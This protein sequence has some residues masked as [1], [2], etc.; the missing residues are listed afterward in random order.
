MLWLEGHSGAEIADVT[1]L[2]S[3]AAAT[4]LSRLRGKLAAHFELPEVDH[5][6]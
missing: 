6:R 5:D 3:G 1:G 4:R 2:T